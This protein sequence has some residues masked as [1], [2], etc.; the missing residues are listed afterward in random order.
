MAHGWR[1]EPRLPAAAWRELSAA[2]RDRAA[3]LEPDR[4]L[5]FNLALAR[6]VWEPWAGELPPFDDQLPEGAETVL[7]DLDAADAVRVAEPRP[8]RLAGGRDPCLAAPPAAWVE[9]TTR[10]SRPPGAPSPGSSRRWRPGARGSGTGGRPHESTTDTFEP[11]AFED[12]AALKES[13]HT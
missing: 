3:V 8:P 6:P 12:A 11:D 9:R 2:M 7:L 5:V 1:T 10:A 4:T 13:A